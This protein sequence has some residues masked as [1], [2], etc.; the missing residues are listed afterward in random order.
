MVIS[1]FVKTIEI[2]DEVYLFH[3]LTLELI[4]V[5]TRNLNN[6]ISS[7]NETQKKILYDA[8]ILVHSEIDDQK[9]LKDFRTRYVDVNFV[10][11]LFLLLT[12]NC[13]FS[14]G[15]CFV[16]N[17]M[18]KGYKFSSMTFETVKKAID[19]FFNTIKK[20]ESHEILLNFPYSIFLFGGEP[21]LNRKVFKDV[22]EYVDQKKHEI[23]GKIEI[24]LVT[25]GSLITPKIVNLIKKHE[26]LVA[27]SLDGKEKIHDIYRKDKKG[28]GTFHQTIKGIKMLRDANIEIGISCTVWHHNVEKMIEFSSWLKENF[29]IYSIGFNDLIDTKGYE[30]DLAFVKLYS[31]KIV[32]HFKWAK[33]E[34]ITNDVFLK[35]FYPFLKKRVMP[36]HCAAH[37]RQMV[38][39]P[40]GKIGLCHEG[41]GENKFFFGHVNQKNFDYWNNP[42]VKEWQKRSPLNIK[43]CEDCTALGLC[44]GGCSYTSYF[45]FG[46][47]WEI[48]ERF[49]FFAKTMVQ[50]I[51]EEAVKFIK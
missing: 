49:C 46:S 50:A 26:V 47:I 16:R 5:D 45:K 21:L 10:K 1:K 8:K 34:G 2:K 15:Y 12:D 41:T 39:S 19:I 14:C 44:G 4:K 48:D 11:T 35:R 40:S 36:Y 42:V 22:L 43:K 29:G 18:K 28:K 38:I 37:G 30:A 7:L 27:V 25:N 32:K 17:F 9:L 3:T 31:Q 23:P 51:I 13:N 24:H 20:N 6:F 33:T